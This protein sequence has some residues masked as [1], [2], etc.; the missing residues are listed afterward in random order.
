MKDIRKDGMSVLVRRIPQFRVLLISVLIAVFVILMTGV[1]AS[2]LASQA[3]LTDSKHS[4]E[5]MTLDKRYV[6]SGPYA[7]YY[8][9]TLVFGRGAPEP[10]CGGEVLTET[11]YGIESGEEDF[12]NGAIPWQEHLADITHVCCATDTGTPIKPYSMFW[13]FPCAWNLQT[14]D[15]SGLDGANVA[16]MRMLF[17]D[18]S[19]LTSV[20]FGDTFTAPKLETMQ[21]A[22]YGCKSLTSL[23]FPDS[24]N[25]KNLK[26]L[27]Q[28]FM[29]CEALTDIHLGEGF[30]GDS[31]LSMSNM[32][33]NCESLQRISF[34]DAFKTSKATT[35]KGMFDWCANL[36]SVDFGAGFDT[37]SV[38][39]FTDMFYYCQNLP[40]LDLS[41]CCFDTS[42]ATTMYRMFYTCSKLESVVFGQRFNTSH[43]EIMTSMFAYDSALKTLTLPAEFNTGNV[44]DMQSMFQSCTSLTSLDVGPAFNT[45]HV[46]N[47]ASM[48]YGDTKL[49]LDCTSW[50][51]S[52]CTRHGSFNTRANKV[53]A[54]VWVN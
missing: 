37:S 27:T 23:R 25:T 52:S 7:A 18:C 43:V 6:A 46:Q 29:G 8:E 47:M 5:A 39:D 14:A 33:R 53:T 51:V 28:A 49:V 16:S 19:A 26:D 30:R 34:P 40:M 24:M 1:D 13:W 21:D 17:Y 48:F 42:S 20:N 50:D 10:T 12:A 45:G 9:G 31:V 32:F 11:Y 36:I 3:Y 4:A 15:L 2:A 44:T 38:T 22:F 54:P 41:T 35:V